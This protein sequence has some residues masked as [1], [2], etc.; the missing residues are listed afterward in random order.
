MVSG[1][2]AKSNQNPFKIL[3]KASQKPR[4]TPTEAEAKTKPR[5]EAHRC[6]SA[7][8]GLGRPRKAYFPNI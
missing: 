2:Q 7:W 1:N 8:E 6:S 5:K 3:V 4:H